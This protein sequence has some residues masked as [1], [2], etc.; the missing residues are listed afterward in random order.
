MSLQQ[1]TQSTTQ[2][3]K[4]GRQPEAVVVLD[5][6]IK[7][8]I[9][10]GRSTICSQRHHQRA[11]SRCTSPTFR[12]QPWLRHLVCLSWLACRS[13]SVCGPGF[14]KVDEYSLLRPRLR[15]CL[16]GWPPR[17][18]QLLVLTSHSSSFNACSN[19]ALCS[20]LLS[21]N[22][23]RWFWTFSDITSRNRASL[24]Y[25]S[26]LPPCQVSTTRF[27][28]GAPGM[29]NFYHRFMSH[30]AQDAPLTI[31]IDTSEIVVSVSWN[32]LSI[33]CG[34]HWHSSAIS[35]GLLNRSTVRL[36]AS[37][38]NFTWSCAFLVILL[39][40]EISL[41]SRITN[42]LHLFS[43]GSWSVVSPP[44]ALSHC[45]LRIHCVSNT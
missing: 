2:H 33:T 21:A 18:Q 3:G 16:P 15:F 42:H 41:P 22:S 9:P 4:Q 20:T 26:G 23:V 8:L 40:V 19:T 29:I 30:I 38:L 37:F 43:K 32:N 13:T 45:S 12:R 31:I 27:R 5:C 1:P 7:H 34:S 6:S 17:C 10:A 39:R 44:A 24:H 25:L 11:T 28:Q 14:P 36:T 35:C